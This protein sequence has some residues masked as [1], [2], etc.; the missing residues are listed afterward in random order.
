LLLESATDL[1]IPQSKIRTTL[2]C[3]YERKLIAFRATGRGRS[4][5]EAME[6]L[7]RNYGEA[8]EIDMMTVIQSSLGL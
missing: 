3:G 5:G 6:K 8:M 1:S 2:F 4:Y 7:W